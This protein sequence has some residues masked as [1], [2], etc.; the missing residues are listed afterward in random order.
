MLF[1]TRKS[2]EF[3]NVPRHVVRFE[4]L[5][6]M[7]RSDQSNESVFRFIRLLNDIICLDILFTLMLLRSRLKILLE[8]AAEYHMPYVET[9]NHDTFILISNCLGCSRC[10]MIVY[11]KGEE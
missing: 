5:L 2:E 1:V 8:N 7:D 6:V 11:L 3:P 9:A 4:N 10:P